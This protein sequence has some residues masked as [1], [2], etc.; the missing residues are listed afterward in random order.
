M[1][2]KIESSLNLLLDAAKKLGAESTTVIANE[3]TSVNVAARLG[4]LE[5]VERNES[6]SIGLEIIDKKRK[7]SLSSTN[8]N[9]E[10]LEELAKNAM[11]MVKSIPIDEYC[12]LADKNMLYYGNLD[13]DLVDNYIPENNDL[14]KNSIEAED[15]ALNIKGITNSEGASSS[16]SKNK[17]YLATSDG[18]FNT[19][20]KTNY[21]TGISVI[22]GKGTKMERDYEY[23]SKVHFSDLDTP[24]K[25]GE[26]AAERAISR[27]NPK[28]VKSN[29][30]PVIFDPRVSGSL[31]SLFIGGI[32]GQAITRGT[33]FLKDKMNK[34]IFKNTINIIDNPHIK[35]GA[36]SLPFDGE[37]VA[38]KKL[39]LVENG[40]LKSWLLNS[41]YA[42]QL[43]LKST[44]HYSGASNLYMSPGKKTN[45]ELIKSIDQGFYIT[46]MLGMSFS[47]VTGDYSRGASGYWIEKGEKAYPVSEVTIAGNILDMYNMLTPASDLK[48][49]TGIDAPTLMIDKMIVAGL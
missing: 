36:R 16:Y 19:N 15:S 24:K 22:A 4:K 34:D 32:S 6:S 29:S 45:L 25:I 10:S 8:L 11:N 44:G 9:K 47:Q 18:F 27:L 49:I 33:S 31:L 48:M 5:N 41:Q 40:K 38:T 13:L 20:D 37:G 2:N 35:R 21:S 30:V 42:R 7:V 12:G 3:N 43:N 14:L 1:A 23:Q 39:K 17:F 28:K 26:K 46:E